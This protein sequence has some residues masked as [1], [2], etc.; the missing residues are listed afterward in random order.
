MTKSATGQTRHA[1][2]VLVFFERGGVMVTPDEMR[3]FAL[4]CLRWSE[5]TDNLSH[6]DLMVQIAK[7]WMR[8]ASA[9]DHRVAMGDQLASPDLRNKLD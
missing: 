1:F 3:L 8:T 5:E 9:I 2:G 4:D 7:M 6:R